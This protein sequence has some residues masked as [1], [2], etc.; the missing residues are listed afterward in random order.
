MAPR[1]H[2]RAARLPAREP[3][4]ILSAGVIAPTGADLDAFWAGLVTGADG[5]SAIERFA[6][7]DL[8]VGRG[9]EIKKFACRARPAAAGRSRR[10]AAAGRG[11]RSARRGW[12][13][14]SRRSGWAIVVGTAL[15]GVEEGERALVER[16]PRRARRARSTIAPGGPWRRTS[17]RAGPVLTVSTACASGAT[18]LGIGAD[19]LRDG[20]GGPRRGRA[21]TTSSAAS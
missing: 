14:T 6:V 8:R 20:P 5:I 18:A 3:I 10:R 1:V 11:G 7:D 17:A 15:G 12:P 16:G 4:A 9:G 19:L 2:G 13:S 21:A